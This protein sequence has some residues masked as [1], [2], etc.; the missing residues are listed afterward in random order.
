MG[1]ETKSI[2]RCERERVMEQNSNND[3]KG[4]KGKENETGNIKGKSIMYR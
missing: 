2:R 1:E 3:I 4:N